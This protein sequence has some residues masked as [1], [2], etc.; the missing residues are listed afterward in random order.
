MDLSKLKSFFLYWEGGG[1]VL[2]P[3]HAFFFY[4]GGFPSHIF[5]S[6]PVFH[7]FGGGGW[8]SSPNSWTVRVTGM[9]GRTALKS[10]LDACRCG[11]VPISREAVVHGSVRP[12]LAERRSA[13]L[14]SFR[15]AENRL[16]G[17]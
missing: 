2:R 9:D 15:C 12:A 10:I 4:R 13:K 1:G 5:L 14:A 6:G 8:E 11:P 17:S 3:S 7:S 16:A